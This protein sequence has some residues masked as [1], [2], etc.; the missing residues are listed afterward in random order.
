MLLNAASLKLREVV[1]LLLVHG[2]VYEQRY[3]YIDKV[4]KQPVSKIVRYNDPCNQVPDKFI[5][6]AI[7]QPVPAIPAQPE[8]LR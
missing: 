8:A 4:T 6:S 2:A 7:T 5:L 3:E 1:S